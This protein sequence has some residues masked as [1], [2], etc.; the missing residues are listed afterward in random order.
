MDKKSRIKAGL[1]FGIVMTI[2]FVL[3]TLI[4]Q[5]HH[6]TKNIVAAV[7]IA[8]FSGALATVLFIWLMGRFVKSKLV[9]EAS[10]L[11]TTEVEIILFETPAN[12]FKGIEAVGGKL[13]LTNKRLVFNS[14]KLNIQNHQLAISLVDIMKVG[15]YKTLG[16]VNNG[17]AVTTAGNTTEKFV[18]EQLDEW[19]NQLASTNRL[20]A[21]H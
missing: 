16:L 4:T 13:F 20:Q 18:V 2:F 19:L 3:Q 12:H 5:N 11:E 15:R 6:T 1:R 14:H 21:L 8:M 7:V 17:L 10:H 9:T